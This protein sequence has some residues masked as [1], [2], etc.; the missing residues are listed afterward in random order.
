M[1]ARSMILLLLW[2]SPLQGWVQPAVVP[3]AT[4]PH[5]G[6][7]LGLDALG[8]GFSLQDGVLQMHMAG[9]LSF[10]YSNASLGPVTFADMA[11]PLNILAFHGHFG[12]VVF[13]DRNLSVRQRVPGTLQPGAVVCQSNQDGFWAWYPAENQLVLHN[14]RGQ[15]QL[16]SPDLSPTQHHPGEVVFMAEHQ[17]RLFL[18][19][20]G[21][22]VYDLFATFLFHIP[23]IQAPF[24]QVIDRKILYLEHDQ[25]KVYDFFLQQESVILLP[26]KGVESFF[27]ADNLL[28]L[29]TG[30]ALKKFHFNGNFY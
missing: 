4:F 9:A 12:Q 6:R 21:I 7:F 2:I 5:T 23:H 8:R 13:L 20:T 27:L 18:A 26:E 1:V 3:D 14:H 15:I 25:L 29:Q 19:G 30:E 22:W 10:S 16:R 17:G 24:F 11:D 28:Y